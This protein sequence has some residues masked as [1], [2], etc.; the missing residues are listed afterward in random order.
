MYKQHYQAEY[1]GA[2][3]GAGLGGAVHLDATAHDRDHR[4][5]QHGHDE[6]GERSLL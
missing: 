4:A 1:R 2:A 3:A 6:H 5:G